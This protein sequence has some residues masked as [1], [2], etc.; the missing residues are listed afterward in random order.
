[1][2]LYFLTVGRA[3]LRLLKPP[4]SLHFTR[5]GASVVLLTIGVGLA[6]M[7]TGNNL[8]YMVFGM[9]L[10]MITASGVLSEISLRNLEADWIFSS[11]CHAQKPMTFRVVLG[12]KKFRLPSFGLSVQIR[13]LTPSKERRELLCGFT[14]IPARSK[15]FQDIVFT[16]TIRGE[17]KLEEIKIETQFPFG[18][19]RKSWKEPLHEN[20]I[21]FPKIRDIRAEEDKQNQRQRQSQTVHSPRGFGDTF[22]GMREFF[23]G[24]NPRR[25]SWKSSAKQSKL[26][27]RET[28]RET[29]K[30]F[31]GSMEPLS[32]WQNLN[33]PELEE[34]I[35]WTASLFHKK[36]QEGFAIGLTAPD[37]EQP[38]S[39]QPPV[40]ENI[41]RFLALFNPSRS[42]SPKTPG[43][44]Y[45][46]KPLSLIQLWKRGQQDGS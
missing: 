31:W 46:E 11:N 3:C 5:L 8:V 43:S 14:F 37:F 35:S 24:D 21:I 10:G 36:F 32:D 7:N 34:A 39:L 30:R 17:H 15:S 23:Y 2:K 20:V 22:W 6:A 41:F 40:L 18:F 38:V 44:A 16:P 4:R 33:P 9:M 19:F 28:E 45:S 29:E 12:N 1:M 42:V 13:V 25:I 26:M 27:V